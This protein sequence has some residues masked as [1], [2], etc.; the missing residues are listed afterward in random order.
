MTNTATL[1]AQPS[2]VI[3]RES[4]RQMSN[5]QLV[6]LLELKNPMIEDI[7]YSDPRWSEMELVDAG[8]VFAPHI[9][10]GMFK[11]ARPKHRHPKCIDSNPTYI[12]QRDVLR[13]ILAWWCAPT[14]KLSLFMFGETG[15]GKTEM[16]LWFADRMNW[17]VSLTAVNESMRPEKAQGSYI[18]FNGKTPYRYGSVASAMKYGWCQIMD[19][20]D[21][22]SGDFLS[23]LH[24]PAEYKPWQLD[25]TGEIITPHKNFRFCATANT[26]GGG[27]MTGRYHTSQRLDEAFR[28]RFAFVE[29]DYPSAAVEDS[30]LSASYPDISK[31]TRHKMIKLAGQMRLALRAPQLEAKATT[32]EALNKLGLPDERLSCAF[33]TRVLVAWADYMT[34]F[35]VK[36]VPLKESFDFVFGNSLD[37]SDEPAVYSIVQRIFG[38]SFDHPDGWNEAK[39]SGK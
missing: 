4:A 5:E 30:I 3:S 13:S 38:E 21:K 32:P 33:S 8:E 35:G 9:P 26:N 1:T 22:G 39:T 15:T 11:I 37:E 25:D 12:P 6:K 23:K 28:R 36:N 24:T 18:L 2:Q 7:V 14:R 17:P 29:C 34:I 19:E 10:K 27:D 20:C 16:L 31:S